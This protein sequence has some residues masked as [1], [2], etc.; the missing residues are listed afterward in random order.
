MSTEDNNSK[1]IRDRLAKR[2]AEIEEKEGKE[3]SDKQRTSIF[4]NAFRHHLKPPYDI[5]EGGENS[6]ANG[7]VEIGNGNANLNP[8]ANANHINPFS[9]PMIHCDYCD[10]A[11]GR[12]HQYVKIDLCHEC[13]GIAS[14]PVSEPVVKDLLKQTKIEI[15]KFGKRPRLGY[16]D[17]MRL[18]G[19]GGFIEYDICRYLH[20]ITYREYNA[21]HQMHTPNGTAV[22]VPDSFI[23]IYKNIGIGGSRQSKIMRLRIEYDVDKGIIVK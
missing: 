19:A 6:V 2:M 20:A 11:M 5:S 18:Y 23:E 15:T 22:L 8:T 4:E 12:H 13:F 7:I 1:A 21:K 3:F 9:W 16:S 17:L 10:K 14:K